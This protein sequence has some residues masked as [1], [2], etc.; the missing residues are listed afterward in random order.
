MGLGHSP[1]SAYP[2]GLPSSVKE[3]HIKMTTQLI[4]YHRGN[5]YAGRLFL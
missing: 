4:S 2:H 1:E 3:G 5:S